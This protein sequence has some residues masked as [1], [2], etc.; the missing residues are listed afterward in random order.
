[1]RI[2]VTYAE[3]SPRSG[4]ALATLRFARHRHLAGPFSAFAR[5]FGGLW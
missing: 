4:S 1:M 3:Q 2:T 5:R